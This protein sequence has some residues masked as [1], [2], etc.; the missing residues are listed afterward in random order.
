MAKNWITA[1]EAAR[2][3]DLSVGGLHELVDRGVLRP[4]VESGGRADA[5][6]SDGP[7]HAL[8][9][10]EDIEAFARVFVRR[11][12]DDTMQDL[13][14]QLSRATDELEQKRTFLTLLTDQKRR[15][16]NILDMSH[17]VIWETDAA[18]RFTFLNQSAIELFGEPMKRLIGRCF[19][20]F[21]AREKHVANRRFL[22]LLRTHGEVR[23]FITSISNGKRTRWLGINAKA[24][25]NADGLIEKMCGTIRDI[26]E[27]QEAE[28]RLRDQAKH[29]PLTGLYNRSALIERL[30]SELRAGQRGAMIKIDIDYFEVV[31]EALGPREGDAVIRA[32]G[33]VLNT[34]LRESDRA[35]LYHLGGDEFA[36]LCR[37][38]SRKAVAALGER[39]RQAIGRY[40][41]RSD[42]PRADRVHDHA[43]G[44]W[45]G[46]ANGTGALTAD[47]A[48]CSVNYTASAGVVLFPF[49]GDTPLEL[50]KNTRV[51]MYMAKEAGRNRLMFFD[52]PNSNPL[53]SA[54]SRQSWYQ[55]IQAALAEDRF[56]LFSQPVCR[57]TD[58]AGVHQEV[59]VRMREG[60]RLLQPGEFIHH[61][62]ENGLIKLIDERVVQKTLSVIRS[63]PDR[64]PR[65][66]VN[67]S[68]VSISDPAWVRLLLD[69]LRREQLGSP[70]LVFEITETAAMR[71]IE[72]AIQF[73]RE[74]KALG[75]AFALDDFGARFSTFDYL[76]KFDVDY[77]KIDGAFA[78]DLPKLAHRRVLVRSICEIAREL[79]KQVVA[80]S[81]EDLA[82]WR[83]FTESGA[84]L[85]QGFY[86]GHPAPIDT[87]IAAPVMRNVVAAC[88][89]H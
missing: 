9:R 53:R 31:N 71:D 42:E 18:G 23:N 29:D 37:E 70:A 25:F 43:N 45:A 80:E 21:E 15:T 62:E 55:R 46:H 3:L 72:T 12:A 22:S 41:Y 82:T 30:E 75:H 36:V 28:Q 19:F 20:S 11:K 61:A 68:R 2:K 85:G 10:G 66:F 6:A 86:F 73:I 50:M 4:K 77:I 51:A 79:D 16:D 35:T 58:G 34:E 67:L 88:G 24:I 69:T 17:D 1:S 7:E 26:T 60:T 48:N 8:Y 32:L 5:P 40:V 65:F 47:E 84:H 14:S 74:V 76:E 87:S 33:G 81:I 56:E 78:Q 49:D 63:R 13:L 44:V 64:V 52:Q 57:L 27:Q 39:L 83:I 38:T 89:V 54:T 59:L